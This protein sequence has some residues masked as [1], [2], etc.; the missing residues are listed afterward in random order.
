MVFKDLEKTYKTTIILVCWALIAGIVVYLV[1]Y[2]NDLFSILAI[3]LTIAYIMLW[4]VRIIENALPETKRVSKRFIAALSAYILSIVMIVVLVSLMVQPVS[5]QLIELSQA[6]P[7]YINQFEE[8]S[9]EFIDSVSEEHGLTFVQNLF[10]S[11]N[12]TELAT[13]A[14]ALSQ[15]EKKLAQEKIVEEKL[16]KQ[17]QTLANHGAQAL[18]EVLLGTL[19]NLIYAVLIIMLSF[20]MLISSGG[21]HNWVQNLFKHKNFDRFLTIESKINRAL[22]GYIRGQALIG[23]ITGVFMWVVYA[24]FNMKFAL[25]LAL[26]MGFGQF[27]PFI[28]QTLAIIPAVI[29]ALV[30]SPVTAFSVLIIFLIFQIFSNNVL[31][32]KILGDFTGLNPILVIIA[33]II[34]ERL[35]GIIGV[36]LA[37]PV[38]SIIQIVLFTIYPNLAPQKPIPKELLIASKES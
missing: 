10:G 21:I 11:D 20:F 38:A 31:V 37:V 32:P 35:A 30:M 9:V 24:G 33:L 26:M 12:T 15:E 6:L 25:V 22:I 34:G 1:G 8:K 5:K 16:Y 36:L 3:S 28:G 4:P 13:E 29:V 19:R 17:L 23:L 27:I 2:F 18:Q 14:E 7:N